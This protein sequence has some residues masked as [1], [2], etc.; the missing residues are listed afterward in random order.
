MFS[1]KFNQSTPEYFVSFGHKTPQLSKVYAFLYIMMSNG[2]K[3]DMR[4]FS[5]SNFQKISSL[6]YEIPVAFWILPGELFI[7]INFICLYV[8][9]TCEQEF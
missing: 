8:L 3:L 9:S 7:C 1:T 5:T 4:K 2:E 6:W